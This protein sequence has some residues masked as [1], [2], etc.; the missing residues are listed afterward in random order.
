LYDTILES[1]EGLKYDIYIVLSIP[2]ALIH[3]FQGMVIEMVFNSEI[4]IYSS[5]QFIF[6]KEKQIFVYSNEK[7]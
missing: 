5:N 4:K 1:N 6:K 3:F 2:C 7:I